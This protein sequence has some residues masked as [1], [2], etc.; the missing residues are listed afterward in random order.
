MKKFH[1][2]GTMIILL[3]GSGYMQA[4]WIEPAQYQ[5]MLGRGIDVD[6]WTAHKNY[7]RQNLEHAI[8]DFNDAGIQHIRI[9]LTKDYL[10]PQDFDILDEQLN[11][12]ISYGVTPIIAYKPAN[13]RFYA[14]SENRISNWWR[15][16]AEHYRNYPA[17][18]S[19]DI[20]LEPNNSMFASYSALNDFY[21][22]CVAT[23]RQSNPYRIIFIAPIDNSNPLNLQY[24]RIPSRA[25]GYLMAEWHFFSEP[26]YSH[27]W[28]NWQNRRAYEERL[29][30]RRI[31]AAL[32]WQRHTG[33]YTWVGGWAP[34]SYFKTNY[35]SLQDAFTVFLCN[36][37]AQARIP[38]SVHGINQYYDYHNRGWHHTAYH[39]MQT[40]F[41]KGNFAHSGIPIDHQNLNM[42]FYIG[43]RR[44]GGSNQHHN[45]QTYY[46]NSS[47][48]QD[49]H[50]RDF[51]IE[52]D[53][54]YSNKSSDNNFNANRIHTGGYGRYNNKTAAISNNSDNN[55]NSSNNYSDSYSPS[56][57]SNGGFSRNK[58]S[59]DTSNGPS[60][61]LQSIPARQQPNPF[62]S[63]SGNNS[64]RHETTTI[65][66]SGKNARQ[67][68][69]SYNNAPQQKNA[70]KRS[71]PS[72]R[73]GSGGFS[74]N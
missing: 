58:A 27:V 49:Q 35:A 45:F 51:N 33:I 43:D 36:A 6:W 5:Q 23:I 15:I 55:S 1:F 26:N 39:N 13:A 7:S 70:E 3:L 59:Q 66:K 62:R 57:Q 46:N 25:N 54:N 67:Q 71:T 52:K 73:N 31:E 47:K 24:L 19:F 42:G 4:Q 41:S 64:F 8:A 9:T 16:M 12:C 48:Q 32:A 10:S 68:N 60:T 29:I 21:E 69:S 11:Q 34:G 50:P 61:S 30:N 22:N 65:R 18:L 14:G 44:F 28:Y 72:E 63:N 56:H 74:R 37:L 17:C 2:L 38:F 53:Q 20:I 40:I